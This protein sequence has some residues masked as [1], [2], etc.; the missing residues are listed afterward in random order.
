MVARVK[1]GTSE[2]LGKHH[3]SNN[4]TKSS[5][6][7]LPSS[8]TFFTSLSSLMKRLH[9]HRNVSRFSR[10]YQFI[11]DHFLSTHLSTETSRLH[12]ISGITDCHVWRFRAKSFAKA[13]ERYTQHQ[14]FASR[15]FFLFRF[16][17]VEQS[18]PLSEVT[19]ISRQTHL[20]NHCIKAKRSFKSATY[21]TS[22]RVDSTSTLR[23]HRSLLLR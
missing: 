4:S 14:H 10:S 3:L 16:W 18:G 12:N 8:R 15:V 5:P 1:R 17:V 20:G 11:K 21:P 22:N 6:K 7:N 2:T 13:L 9:G 19:T 23:F